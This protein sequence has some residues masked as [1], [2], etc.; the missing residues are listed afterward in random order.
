MDGMTL[1]GK[2]GVHRLWVTD[3]ATGGTQWIPLIDIKTD[4]ENATLA[5]TLVAGFARTAG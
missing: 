1:S 2:N 5:R 4:Q 3:P